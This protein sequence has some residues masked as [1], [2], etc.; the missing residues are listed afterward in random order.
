VT[1]DEQA[2]FKRLI[3]DKAFL[4]FLYRMIRDAGI[5]AISPTGARD[6]AFNE[7]RRSL[8]LDI[9]REAEQAQAAPSPDGL[10][11]LTSIQIFLSVAQSAPKE[12]PLGR[13]SDPYGDLSDGDGSTC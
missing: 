9:L 7:G 1:P 4:A 8:A 6:I 5:F 10:P 3:A 2:D 12:K 13:R 11:L